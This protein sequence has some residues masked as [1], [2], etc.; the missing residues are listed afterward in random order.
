MAADL[1]RDPGRLRAHAATAA[2]LA[3]ELRV[4]AARPGPVDP[5]AD[6]LRSAV[7]RTAAELADLG[8]ELAAA[9]SAAEGGDRAAAAAFA[10]VARRPELRSPESRSPEPRFSE[11]R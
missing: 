11:P 1:H 3:D 6:R 10:S 8:A 7:R 4:A 9:A 5:T 2:A